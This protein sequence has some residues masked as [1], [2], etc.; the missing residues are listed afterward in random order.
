M[1]T[2]AFQIRLCVL[3][4]LS[5]LCAQDYRSFLNRSS[6]VPV[7][8]DVFMIGSNPGVM[9]HAVS[10]GSPNYYRTHSSK[11]HNLEQS[12]RI[13]RHSS[14]GGPNPFRLPKLPAV[15]VTQPHA[16]VAW[17]RKSSRCASLL[18]LQK[19][20]PTAVSVSI[21]GLLQDFQ[22]L[23]NATVN[24][25]LNISDYFANATGAARNNKKNS[26]AFRQ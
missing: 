2:Q 18:R 8:T 13:P 10:L 14:R 7:L 25:S 16:S 4:Q 23:T 11:E 24:S 17:D 3:K 19:E 6:Q 12:N 9:A 5:V 15:A 20:A 1:L 22:S 26:E 21:Q